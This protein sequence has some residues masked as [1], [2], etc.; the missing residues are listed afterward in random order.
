MEQ[1]VVTFE[2]SADSQDTLDETN[3]YETIGWE[4]SC[5]SKRRRMDCLGSD[6]ESEASDEESDIASIIEEKISFSHTYMPYGP[7]KLSE[8]SWNSM[9]AKVL[10]QTI[11]NAFFQVSKN[12]E[13]KNSFFPCFLVS[14]K[15]L[16]IHMY[17]PGLDILLTYP[18][19][20]PIFEDYGAYLK[21]DTE[22]ILC[23]WLALNMHQ[24]S[25]Q[26]P[27]ETDEVAVDF[28]R[29]NFVKSNFPSCVGPTLLEIYKNNLEAPLPQR[30]SSIMKRYYY[31]CEV[32]T[33]YV[34]KRL[35]DF[36]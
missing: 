33:D 8:K 22:T 23:L 16:T 27:N 35:K 20:L 29:K 26:L 1:S 3:E 24:F 11:V 6:D 21:L 28:A 31:N 30:E 2:K 18:A 12:P 34:R 7:E 10:S 25:R 15:Y 17:N 36:I 4:E 13:L 14:D 19:T 32:S 5:G 9:H